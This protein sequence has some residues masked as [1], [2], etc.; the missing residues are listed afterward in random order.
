MSRGTITSIGFNHNNVPLAAMYMNFSII[1]ECIKR[2]KKK[3][4]NSV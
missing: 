2:M 1:R 3:Q 4:T